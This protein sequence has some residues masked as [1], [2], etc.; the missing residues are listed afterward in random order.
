MFCFYFVMWVVF[1]VF[2]CRLFE[3]CEEVGGGG[4]EWELLGRDKGV[5]LEGEV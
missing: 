1:L 5:E 2:L 3:E 4:E